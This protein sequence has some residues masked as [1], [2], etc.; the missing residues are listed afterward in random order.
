MKNRSMI[1]QQ[2]VRQSGDLF[3]E[4][5]KGQKQFFNEKGSKQTS[6]GGEE[7]PANAGRTPN[8]RGV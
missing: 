4:I 8:E 6:F 3:K 2:Q 7:S 5:M 1:E